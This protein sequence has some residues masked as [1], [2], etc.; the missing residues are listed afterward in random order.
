[1]AL[2]RSSPHSAEMEARRIAVTG[3]NLNPIL[4]VIT[5]LLLAVV[6]LML[7]FRLVAKFF[8]K[9]RQ[10]PGWEDAFI[11]ASY[12]RDTVIIPRLSLIFE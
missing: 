12:V 6:T 10:A 5:W 11:L 4:Q 2:A 1:M 9:A 3:S 7:F 8:L